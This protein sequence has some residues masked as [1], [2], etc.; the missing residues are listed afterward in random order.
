[1]T[2]S[3][4]STY[5]SPLHLAGLRTP[6]L[7]LLVI[8]TALKPIHKLIPVYCVTVKENGITFAKLCLPYSLLLAAYFVEAYVICQ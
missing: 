4:L 3:G 7:N 6:V 8:D 5:L 2:C 1:M